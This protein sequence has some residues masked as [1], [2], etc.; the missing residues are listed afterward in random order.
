MADTI[1]YIKCTEP[2]CD[3]IAE[4]RQAGGKRKSLYTHCPDCGTNQ[5]S[6][7]NRQKYLKENLK[8]SRE[9]LTVPVNNLIDGYKS[10]TEEKAAIPTQN[11]ASSVSDDTDQIPKEKPKAD[12][13][14][15]PK[16]MAEESP[17]APPVLLG[18]LALFATL[19]T[20]IFAS[21]KPKTKPKGQTA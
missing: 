14:T 13:E 7:V 20:A 17:A 21:R 11:A 2:S 12:T 15:K 1:G 10:D 6:G 5:A 16:G 18:A 4:V 3:C 19:I 8:G 9:E